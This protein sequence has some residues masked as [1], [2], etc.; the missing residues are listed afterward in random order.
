MCQQDFNCLLMGDMYH[1][2]KLHLHH[3]EMSLAQRWLVSRWNQDASAGE[4][5]R[6]IQTKVCV[7]FIDHW[8]SCWRHSV[9]L[10]LLFWLTVQ[11]SFTIDPVLIIWC[12]I[13]W[14]PFP[15]ASGS[16]ES[17][18]LIDSQSS[19]ITSDHLRRMWHKGDKY[20]KPQIA[21]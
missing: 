2:H 7:V 16:S 17:Y 21:D 6:Y 18:S 8:N 19:S 15:F 5:F 11:F 3:L 12:C 13:Q 4:I 20:Q 1:L 10:L 9:Y 14:G